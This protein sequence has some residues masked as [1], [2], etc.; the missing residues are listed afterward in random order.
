MALLA[1]FCSDEFYAVVPVQPDSFPQP[2]CAL[3]RREKCLPV[4][5]EMLRSGDL[6]LQRFLSR[7]ATR[8][9]ERD[10]IADLEGSAHFFLNINEREDYESALRIC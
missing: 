4:V 3:Y 8:Y 10:E 6:K 7:I 9:V 2:L 5:E 1:G